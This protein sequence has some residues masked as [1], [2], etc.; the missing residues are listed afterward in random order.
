[1]NIYTFAKKVLGIYYRL[2]KPVT[3]GVR[4]I[5][6]DGKNGILLV[7]HKYDDGLFYIPGGGVK[8]GETMEQAAIREVKEECGVDVGNLKI[9][10]VYSNFT[11]Y[12]NDHIA[13]FFGKTNA[14]PCAH[15]EIS[16]AKFFSVD[17]LPEN[18]SKGS[19]RRIKEYAENKFTCGLW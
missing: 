1:M 16:E 3:A 2:F 11:E 17:S 19:A 9:L 13:L 4:A 15:G 6:T 7:R 12:K 5:I 14:T 10:S 18:I 8:K